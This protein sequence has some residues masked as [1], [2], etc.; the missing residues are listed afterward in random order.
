MS[1]VAVDF[2]HYTYV[3]STIRTKVIIAQVQRLNT[4][5]FLEV[6]K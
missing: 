3:S 4:D 1:N 6:N 2:E 5:V